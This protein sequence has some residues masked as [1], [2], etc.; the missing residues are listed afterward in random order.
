MGFIL[1]IR[2]DEEPEKV[3]VYLIEVMTPE[4]KPQG[5]KWKDEEDAPGVYVLE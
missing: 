2:N 5:F 3:G 1:Q 4:A